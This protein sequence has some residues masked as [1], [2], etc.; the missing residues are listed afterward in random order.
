MAVSAAEA[1]YELGQGMR[2]DLTRPNIAGIRD[3]SNNWF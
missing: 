1:F 2:A 3:S